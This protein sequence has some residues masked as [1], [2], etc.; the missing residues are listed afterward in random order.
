MIEINGKKYEINLDI[1]WGSQKFMKY[2]MK[3]P[4]GENADKYMEFVLKDI[5]IPAPTLKD[6]IEFRASDIENIFDCFTKESGKQDKEY[7]K[8]LSR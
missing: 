8:K 7:K 6:M 1:K 5:L 3:H 4:D 2:I